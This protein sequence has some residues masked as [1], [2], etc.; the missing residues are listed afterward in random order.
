[1]AD[2]NDGRQGDGTR[3]PFAES[4]CWTCANHREIGAAR[5]TFILCAAL[6]VKYPRQ[7]V[8]TC[9]AYQAGSQGAR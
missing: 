2:D 6:A 9:P 1:M 8:A 7:P 3:R 5:S 4:I